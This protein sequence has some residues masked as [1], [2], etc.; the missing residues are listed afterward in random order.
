MAFEDIFS[1]I[2][3]NLIALRKSE[4]DRTYGGPQVQ[5]RNKKSR[6]NKFQLAAQQNKFAVKWNVTAK[7]YKRTAKQYKL[8]AEQDQ[9]TAKYN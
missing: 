6:Q 8:T 4:Y 5:R 2:F 1:R 3:K 7:Q 9:L